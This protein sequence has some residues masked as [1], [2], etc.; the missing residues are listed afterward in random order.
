MRFRDFRWVGVPVEAYKLAGSRGDWAGIRRQVIVAGSR[1]AAT[2]FDV[3]YFEIDPGGF[4]TLEQHQHAHVVIGLQGTGMIRTGRRW[5]RLRFLDVCYVEPNTIH[6]LRN[7]GPQRFG[8]LCLV[9]AERDT[10]RV[11]TTR[12]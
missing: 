8:F 12:R 3:R 10:P 2:A 11:V 9:D 4:S 6:R 5:Q 1:G 7:D